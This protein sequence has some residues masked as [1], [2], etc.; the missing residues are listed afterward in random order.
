MAVSAGRCPRQVVIRPRRPSRCPSLNCSIPALATVIDTRTLVVICA[1]TRTRPRMAISYAKQLGI[2]AQ[3][4]GACQSRR[5]V[6]VFLPAPDLLQL[7]QGMSQSGS[8]HTI[9]TSP[10][11]AAASPH[12]LVGPYHRPTPTIITLPTKALTY[13][14]QLCIGNPVAIIYTTST[15]VS[16]VNHTP[17]PPPPS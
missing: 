14:V 9:H 5:V 8:L 11:T 7:A 12:R 10:L 16:T 2:G 15:P 3:P 6:L 1:T 13:S 17:V 4:I